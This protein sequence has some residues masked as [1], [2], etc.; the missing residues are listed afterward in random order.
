ME[1]H[2]TDIES[3][4]ITHARC[5][6]TI[7]QEI[8]NSLFG[9]TR[10][11]RDDATLGA[12]LALDRRLG[13]LARHDT[14]DVALDQRLELDRTRRQVL[15]ADRTLARVGEARAW[16]LDDG[17]LDLVVDANLTTL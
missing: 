16:V 5:F 2:L 1:T 13:S 15:D 17:E 10:P 3:N 12:L 4:F 11:V 7:F 8:H 9:R 6:I 14:F